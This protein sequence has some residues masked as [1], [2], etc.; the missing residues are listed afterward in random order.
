MAIFKIEDKY[1]HVLAYLQPTVHLPPSLLP[2]IS[3]RA[4]AALDD[5]RVLAVEGLPT[6]TAG[7]VAGALLCDPERA[8]TVVMAGWEQALVQAAA[9]HLGLDPV[10]LDPDALP[11]SIAM[12]LGRAAVGLFGD[13]LPVMD[14]L[15]IEVAARRGAAI[16]ALESPAR[17]ASVLAAVPVREQHEHLMDM[18]ER[19]LS[20]PDDLAEQ[21]RE[22]AAWAARAPLDREPPPC[23]EPFGSGRLAAGLNRARNPGIARRI[24]DLV[25]PPRRWVVVAVGAGHLSGPDGLC[26]H[27]GEHELHLVRVVYP[28]FPMDLA[29]VWIQGLRRD[30]GLF[31]AHPP[32]RSGGG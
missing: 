21:V 26:A 9:R 30:A 5:C 8:W 13:A 28:G 20:D 6:A 29:E 2:P 4:M 23:Q 31:P 22:V 19:V 25:R 1:G 14:D 32:A 15:L 7:T 10:S 16:A 24:A 11:I 17:V 18:V 27:L 3:Q 12:R